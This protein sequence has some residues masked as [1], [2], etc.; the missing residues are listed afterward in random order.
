[1]QGTPFQARKNG[2]RIEDQTD[3]AANIAGS[4]HG[5][6]RADEIIKVAMDHV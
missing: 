3:M 2:L 6:E 1:M 5:V 4:D